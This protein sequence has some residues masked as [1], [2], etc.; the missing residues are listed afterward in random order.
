MIEEHSED[1]FLADLRDYQVELKEEDFERVV[2]EPGAVI[3]LGDQIMS[4]L[5]VTN[6]DDLRAGY[7]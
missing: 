5:T 1:W 7:C 4:P 3:V 6:L 2:T